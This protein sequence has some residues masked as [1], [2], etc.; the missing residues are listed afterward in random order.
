MNRRRFCGLAIGTLAA[1]YPTLSHP[2]AAAETAKPGFFFRDGDRV[3]MIGDSIT[4]QLLHSNYVETY[5]VSRFPGWNLAFRNVGI[6]GDTS[7]GGNRRTARDIL[8]FK[9]T[10]V[11][12]TFGMN[13]GGYR[14]PYDPVRL[15]AYVTGLQAMVAQIKPAGARI[16]ILSSSPV[17]KAEAGSALEGYNQTLER[18][19]EGAKGVAERGGAIFVDQFHPHLAT[20]Q[21]ARDASPANRIN[22]G[23]PVHP[24]PSGQLLMAWAILKG[25]NAPALVSSAE[26]DAAA[27]KVAAA[28]RCS[29][30]AVRKTGDGISFIRTD[31]A[32]PFHIPP[33]ARPILQWAPVVEDLDRYLLK[34]TGL[35][36]GTYRLAVDGEA[37]GTV[38][39]ADLSRG[40]NMALLTEG[41]VA[42]QTQ[43]VSDAVFAKNRYYHDQVFRGVVLNGQVPEAGKAALIEERMKGMPA[44]EQSLRDALALRPH[45]F[46]LA[47]VSQ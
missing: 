25:L 10:A 22:G 7:A 41:P 21:K 16:A 1:G 6:G 46:E 44:L 13:D 40:Y 32:L 38:S 8:S 37:C 29:V 24:G 27:G 19:A 31:Q 39:A 34:V 5:A 26:I 11:T 3:V 2:V 15:E 35:P 28:E 30:I 47:R 20:L 36:G 4:E 45:R 12:I 14:Q 43:A 18:L 9:P 23:D 33:A 17:E 42:R